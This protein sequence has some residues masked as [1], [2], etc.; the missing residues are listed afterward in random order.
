M[1]NFFLVL[2]IVGFFLIQTSCQKE[3]ETATPLSGQADFG[4]YLAV[5]GS[6]AAGFS[7]GVLWKE[8]QQASYPVLLAQQFKLLGGGEFSVPYLNGNL[9]VYPDYDP[10]TNNF[11]RTKARL[12][13]TVFTDCKGNEVML[14]LRISSQGDN[15]IDLNNTALK[16]ANPAKPY[17]HWCIPAMKMTDVIAIGYGE[18]VQYTQN[19][20]FSPFFWR[21]VENSNFTNVLYECTKL[22]HTF[23]TLDLGTSDVLSYATEGGNG[24]NTDK[25]SSL[26]DF[27]YTAQLLLDSLCRNGTKGVIANIPEIWTFPYFTRIAYNSLDLT[28]ERA[29][30]LNS[31]YAGSGL[32]FNEGK[33]SFVLKEGSNLRFATS[34]DLITLKTPADSLKCASWGAEKPLTE[35]YVITQ[36]ELSLI[37]QG[38]KDFNKI[39]DELAA[40]KNIPVVDLN[41]FFKNLNNG[42][43]VDGIPFNSEMVSGGFFSLD[44]LHPS[45]RGQA[46][47]ANEFLRV[48]NKYYEATVPLVR[49]ASIPGIKFP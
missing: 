7:D 18:L 30:E 42:I 35:E 41:T 6:M 44:G 45:Q 26:P 1:R 24:G 19:A 32:V 47:I 15:E 4:S 46:L 48:I 39:L 33:N 36:Q 23:F 31:F 5:G 3:F 21:M 17:Q 9:G 40:Q 20:P 13:L 11:S 25:I 14:P 2:A 12:K 49:V 43:N 16:V 28:A 8:G 29:A 37:K 10:L 34:N 38:V 22:K 27:T